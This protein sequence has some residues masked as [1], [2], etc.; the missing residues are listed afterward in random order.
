VR[1]SLALGATLAGG[2]AVLLALPV[3]A[4][5]QNPYEQVADSPHNFLGTA[6]MRDI[7]LACHIAP[8]IPVEGEADLLGTAP[9]WG[10]AGTG[11]AVFPVVND[12]AGGAGAPDTSGRCLEC[13]DGVVATAVH[14]D[15]GPIVPERGGTKPPDHPIRITYPRD[16]GGVFLVATPLP[17]NRQYW[18]VPDIRAG[19]LVL[20]TGPASTYQDATGTDLLALTF[21]LVRVRDGQVACESCHNPHSNQTPPFLRQM[22]PGLCLVCHNK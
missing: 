3:A 6:P 4:S 16:P 19:A 8:P 13:H 15:R 14:T 17:Q 20:P 12:P 9:L 2:M 5:A 11:D 22:P 1:R 18:S 21:G 7:C 10:G